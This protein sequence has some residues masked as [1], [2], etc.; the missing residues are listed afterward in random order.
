[1][2]MA[3]VSSLI[4]GWS[5]ALRDRIIDM[6]GPEPRRSTPSGWTVMCLL[7]NIGVEHLSSSV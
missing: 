7:I 3:N 4:A 6:T 5:R 2:A 1:M